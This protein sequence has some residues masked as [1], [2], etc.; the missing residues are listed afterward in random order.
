MCAISL[1][2]LSTQLRKRERESCER[3]RGE[4]SP[5]KA[6]YSLIALRTR[7]TKRKRKGEKNGVNNRRN[8]VTRCVVGTQMP[9]YRCRISG[10]RL[11]RGNWTRRK[12][13]AAQV[14]ATGHGCGTLYI[15]RWRHRG[16]PTGAECIKCIR[17]VCRSHTLYDSALALR[18]TST[19]PLLKLQEL[20]IN[21]RTRAF[22]A[23]TSEIVVFFSL[24]SDQS[25]V[26][27]VP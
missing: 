20:P 17:W 11:S 12:E 24:F 6:F 9:G 22:F 14:A 19:A 13:L 25:R 21:C 5:S 27:A 1:T 15:G 7:W 23:R 4:L 26:H 8:R 10:I 16:L 3:W 2:P 18:T